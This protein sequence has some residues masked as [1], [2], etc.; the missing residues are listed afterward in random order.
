MVDPVC[1]EYSPPQQT[2]TLVTTPKVF[3]MSETSQTVQNNANTG[4]ETN[5]NLA[6]P[7]SSEEPVPKQDPIKSAL[8]ISGEQQIN[9]I[10]ELK[11]QLKMQNQAHEAAMQRKLEELQSQHQADLDNLKQSILNNRGLP[12]FFHS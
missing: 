4:N 2:Q 6:V 1:T 3:E 10:R 11:E 7:Q 8:L 9:E 12:F 5:N